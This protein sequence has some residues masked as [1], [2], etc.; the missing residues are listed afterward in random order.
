MESHHDDP[1]FGAAPWDNDETGEEEMRMA[2]GGNWMAEAFGKNPGKLHRRLHVPEGQKI[3]A[4]KL[5]KASKSGDPSLRKE[6]ALAR[7]GRRYGG[8]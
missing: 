5:S 2:K 1:R 4:K 3:P 7:V 8:H 6:V